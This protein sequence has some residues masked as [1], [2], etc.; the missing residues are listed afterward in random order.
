VPLGDTYIEL[1]A[2]VDEAEAAQ[3]PV[4]RWV[5]DV[6]PRIARPLGW[7]LRTHQLEDVA[8]RL[9]LTVAAVSRATPDGRL[10]RGRIAGIEQAAAEPSL[11]FF[12]EWREGTSFPGSV[13]ATHRAGS[14]QIARL[15]LSGDADRLA[16]WLGP[17]DLPITIHAGAPAVA[18]IVL[19]G[20]AGE[21]VVDEL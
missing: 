10:L 14:V 9:D 2:V 19:T 4:G 20:D 5:G 3:S 1:I 11:P 17:H 8:R 12:I 21:I 13:P 18:S 15:E 6:P 16:D 7:A